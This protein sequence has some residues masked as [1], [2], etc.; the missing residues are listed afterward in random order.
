VLIS[1]AISEIRT[2]NLVL[3]EFQREYVW[4]K[5]QAKQLLVSLTLKY[6]VGGLLFWK[7]Q[8][9]PELKNVDKMPEKLGA[10]QVI[11]DGQQRLTTLYMLMTGEIP[12]YYVAEDI[13]NDVRDL[14]YNVDD[15]DFQYFQ[16]V[17]MRDNPRWVRVV[18]CFD[19]DSV[20]VFSIA[21]KTV[22]E[23]EGAF[24]QA[25]EYNSNLSKLKGVRDVQLP[26][27]VIPTEASLDDA[28]D[29][30]DR[31]NSLGTKLTEAELA[32]THVTGKWSEARKTLKAKMGQLKQHRFEFDLTFMT[33]SF[34][35]T[36]T[37]HALFQHI[38]QTP[39]HQ[40]EEG[41]G[42]L[43]KI[44]DYMAGILPSHAHIH[45]TR[46]MSTLNPLIP[47]VRFL[48][49]NG[50][51]FPSDASLRR[52]MHWLHV[53][54]IH[55]RYAGQTD[56]RLEHDVTIVNREDSPWQSLVNQIVDQRGRV[57][58]LPDDFEGRGSSHPLYRMSLVLAKANGAVDWF[59]GLSLDAPVGGAYGIHSHHIFPQS[60]LYKNG[61]SSE[62]H[63]DRQVVNAIANRAFLTGDTNL[64]I[65]SRLPEDYLPEVEEGFP[66]ALSSQFIP[67][68][69]QLWKLGR[70]R[71]FLSVRRELIAA[72]LNSFLDKLISEDEP[73]AVRPLSDLI[74]M[75]EGPGLEFKSTLQWDVVE[76][77][78]NKHLR[79]TV[80][81]TLVAFM[82]SEGGTLL[83]GV[84]DSGQI[85]GLERDLNILGGSQDRFLQLLNS[86]VADRIG[87]Q[88]IPH[89]AVRMDA[90]D[91]KLVCIVD[92]SKSAEPA[93]M[94]GQRG[95]EFYIRVGNTTRALDPE[96]TLAYSQEY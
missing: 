93:F 45:S 35:C 86:L 41:W 91:G 76:G 88:F 65:G 94:S 96:Q 29:V 72:G 66:G 26:T 16:P 18:D 78:A 74:S 22:G 70:Y 64:S 83:I 57:N 34:V 49:L 1:E 39:R 21:Q 79:D 20:D 84:E 73:A 89:V 85:F 81:K 60:E 55:Q 53:A 9:P 62:S 87:I 10:L 68:D 71:D 28:I 19:G 36:V 46:D 31:V 52:G 90:V 80:L 13:T 47:I 38:H 6:P 50:G 11:L 25:Q 23:D 75:G 17:R 2:Q 8:E 67:E 77:R 27:Q 24:Q 82:N 92:T 12:P 48:N 15:G 44:L 33:R 51:R 63:L 3:P 43:S 14:Y 7:T 54:Q 61:F 42:R 30:F 95:R 58:V 5:E 59:N 40:L 32:L 4:S 69:T 56:S 37:D